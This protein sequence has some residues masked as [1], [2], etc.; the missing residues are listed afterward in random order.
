M[1]AEL[2][3]CRYSLQGLLAF[4]GPVLEAVCQRLM[5]LENCTPGS[6]H[7]QAAVAIWRNRSWA[8][9]VRMISPVVREVSSQSV[10][11]S[12]DPMNSSERRTELLAF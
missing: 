7:S 3:R 6:A 1:H 12:S 10:P 2:S 5:V 8:G 9:R 11:S 4:I